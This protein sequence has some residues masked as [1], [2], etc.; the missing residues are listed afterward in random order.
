MWFP[1]FAQRRTHSSFAVKVALGSGKNMKCQIKRPSLKLGAVLLSWYLIE[2]GGRMPMR[3]S[4][5]DAGVCLYFSEN[6]FFGRLRVGF[7]ERNKFLNFLRRDAD[8]THD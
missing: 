6:D 7:C 5:R 2:S 3:R 1:K 8:K 4:R